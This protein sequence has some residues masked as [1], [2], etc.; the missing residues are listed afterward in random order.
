MVITPY[1][2]PNQPSLAKLEKHLDDYRMG[3]AYLTKEVASQVNREDVENA[4]AL[5]GAPYANRNY[6]AFQTALPYTKRA[7]YVRA[8]SM[9]FKNQVTG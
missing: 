8:L 5:G 9:T 4:T 3:K 1:S 6:L 2:V 7:R